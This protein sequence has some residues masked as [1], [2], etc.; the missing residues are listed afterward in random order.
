MRFIDAEE[1]R[2]IVDA[3][4][5]HQEITVEGLGTFS[6][7]HREGFGGKRRSYV[8]FLPDKSFA[9]LVNEGRL[10][11]KRLVNTH[12]ELADALVAKRSVKLPGLGELIIGAAEAASNFNVPVFRPDKALK[13]AVQAGPPA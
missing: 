7:A 1:V 5:A 11:P 8:V 3:L 12:S 13:Q 9:S 6:V 10:A 2:S 4:V